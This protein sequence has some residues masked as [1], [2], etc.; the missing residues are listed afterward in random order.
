MRLV[1]ATTD[2][3]VIARVGRHYELLVSYNGG[4]DCFCLGKFKT[5]KEALRKRDLELST[6]KD[7]YFYV[8]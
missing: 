3:Y 5:E 8:Y 1:K 7:G 2:L 4:W 6:A